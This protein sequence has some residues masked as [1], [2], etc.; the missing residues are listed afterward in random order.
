MPAA[1]P[2]RRR[3]SRSRVHTPASTSFDA[4][5]NFQN[6]PAALALVQLR[7]QCDDSCPS[8]IHALC[9]S[10]GDLLRRN[11]VWKAPAHSTCAV[12]RCVHDPLTF[13]DGRR[14]ADG[15]CTR[16]CRCFCRHRLVLAGRH[17]HSE[18]KYAR[19]LNCFSSTRLLQSIST[20]N[21]SLTPALYLL[22]AR[23]RMNYGQIDDIN[24]LET[25][26]RTIVLDND[27]SM[28]VD[29]WHLY[30]ELLLVP[31]REV[32]LAQLL[33][34]QEVCAR[35]VVDASEKRSF[36]FP[37]RTEL[38]RTLLRRVVLHP[39]ENFPCRQCVSDSPGARVDQCR[40]SYAVPA[41][42]YDSS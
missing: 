21:L 15:R 42:Y 7:V 3:P 16:H 41:H 39:T 30:A 5:D 23:K 14:A 35:R 1:C 6:Q 38:T 24:E 37:Q 13:V 17:C 40:S 28:C 8:R 18:S 12:A 10:R 2:T 32:I 29:R 20:I 19:S 36:H 9:P 4:F 34:A 33:F 31:S 25:P 11:R 22:G 26:F 27:Q